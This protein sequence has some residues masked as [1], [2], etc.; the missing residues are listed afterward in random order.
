MVYTVLL[1][2][3]TS[4]G[5]LHLVLARRASHSCRLVFSKGQGTGGA[6]TSEA[7]HLH[8]KSGGDTWGR[9]VMLFSHP[10]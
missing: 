4:S 2:L 9:V 6:G 10:L 5:F 1:G 3:V 8:G 7:P